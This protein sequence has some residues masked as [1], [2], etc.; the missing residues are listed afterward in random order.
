LVVAL[1]G[2]VPLS[3]IAATP[4]TAELGWR[5]ADYVKRY[6]NVVRS[7]LASNEAQFPAPGDGRVIVIF[8][9]GRSKEEA[10]VIGRDPGIVPPKL[11]EQ[12]R[13]AV[14]GKAVRRVDF[15]AEGASPAE[16]FEARHKNMMVQVDDRAGYIVRVSWCR[17]AERCALLDR[18]L[19]TELAT[20]DLTAR[21]Q[22]EMRRQ[23]GK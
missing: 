1:A 18:L 23:H 13:H 11:M 9:D 6:G 8:A 12:A 14:R 22:A 15:R 17:G 3:A 10:W 2:V 7:P 4:A 20:D 19:K 5:E 16:I 21:V